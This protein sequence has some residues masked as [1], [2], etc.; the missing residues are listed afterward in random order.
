MSNPSIH[1]NNFIDNPVALQ[2]FS[3]IYIDARE[4]WW[5]KAPPDVSLIWGDLDRNINIKPWLEKPE[6]K[7][8]RGR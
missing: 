7:A 2:I 4:N 8:F 5:G 3:S 6:D 1:R